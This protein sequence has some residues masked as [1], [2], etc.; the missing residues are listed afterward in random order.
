MKEMTPDEYR[1]FLL[2][3]PRTAKLATVRVDGRPHIAPIWFDLDGDA[4]IFMTGEN[5]VK[6]KYVRRDPRVV[7]CID[8]D[9]PPYAFV[10]F[11]GTAQIM[12]P[13]P[14]EFL[15]WST[16]IARRYM[17]AALADSYG[18]RNAVPGELLIRVV[19]T[20]VIAQQGISD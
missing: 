7:F 10:L 1:H 20:H 19:P 4:L 14:E 6:G 18:K 13:T 9:K 2:D 16:R 17:G 3:T 11:E 12:S 5:T 15:Y 8:D